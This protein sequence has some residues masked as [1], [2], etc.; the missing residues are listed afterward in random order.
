MGPYHVPEVSPP[1]DSFECIKLAR[2]ILIVVFSERNLAAIHLCLFLIEAS[3]YV[4]LLSL[5][6]M[7]VKDIYV[8]HVIYALR[9]FEGKTEIGICSLFQ[10]YD[11]TSLFF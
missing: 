1:R 5:S 10:I 3:N 7:Y 2:I 11:P 9:V 8:I 6:H 4:T